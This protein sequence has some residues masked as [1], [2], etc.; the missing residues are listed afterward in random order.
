MPKESVL[1]QNEINS[2]Q[3]E[4]FIFHI[5]VTDQEEPHYLEEAELSLEQTTFFR[6]RLIEASKGTQYVF[7]DKS[8]SDVFIE[9]TRIIDN[10]NTHFI[11]SSEALTASFK[12]HHSKQAINGVYI[13]AL[14]SI[15]KSRNLIFLLKIDHTKV[16]EYKTKG[17]KVIIEEIKNSFVEDKNAVQKV[18]I[19]D[20]SDYYVWD[21]LVQDKKAGKGKIIGD[22]F[23]NYLY[24]QE[25]ETDS[26][27][28]KKAISVVRHWATAQKQLVPG[29]EPSTFKQKAINYL[30][31]NDVFDTDDF[32]R[33]MIK[34]EDRSKKSQLRQSL[35]AILQEEGLWGQSFTP[36]KGTINSTLRKNKI[37]TAEGLLIEWEGE[38]TASNILISEKDSND[39]YTITIRTSDYKTLN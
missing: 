16:Y 17:S 19:I 2:L 35:T 6:E 21:A 3:I 28:T 20:V 38:A 14:V 34:D 9:C 31:N 39:M 33:E 36:Q 4:R 12:R 13:I 11:A 22:Y 27:L 5:I 37:R 32:I 18:A 30:S 10:H 1:T 8:K 26:V 23:K 29:I 24:V 15:E 7:T 25:R